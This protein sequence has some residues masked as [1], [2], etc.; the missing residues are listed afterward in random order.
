[1]SNFSFLSDLFKTVCIFTLTLGWDNDVNT[2]FS[3]EENSIKQ[4]PWKC[5]FVM[6]PRDEEE[7]LRFV[8]F[9]IFTRGV[10]NS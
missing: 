5:E 6:F 4:A 1:M 3:E 10:T 7:V 2:T 8:Y 9:I